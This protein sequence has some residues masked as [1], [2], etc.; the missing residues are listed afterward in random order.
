MTIAA[1]SSTPIAATAGAPPIPAAQPGFGEA[2]DTLLAHPSDAAPNAMPA[3]APTTPTAAATVL[4]AEPALAAMTMPPD[5]LP[6]PTLQPRAPAAVVGSIPEDTDSA[7]AS[8]ADARPASAPDAPAAG[9][10]RSGRA[11]VAWPPAATE[12]PAPFAPAEPIA[13]SIDADAKIDRPVGA[14]VSKANPGSAD[15]DAVADDAGASQPASLPALTQP[16]TVATSIAVPVATLASNAAA[17]PAGASA[18]KGD[19][20][21]SAAATAATNALPTASDRVNKVESD[22]APDAAA[23]SPAA[24]FAD[25][26]AAQAAPAPRQE[27]AGAAPNPGPLAA[28]QPATQATPAAA[29]AAPHQPTVTAQAGQIGR[30]MGVAIA[31]RVQAG[32]SELIVRLNPAEMGRIEVTLAFDHSGSLRA[33]VAAESPAA[34]DLLRRDSADLGRALSDAGVRADAQS[35]R[36]DSGTGSRQQSGER[37][38]G[39]AGS[40]PRPP[41]RFYADEASPVDRPTFRALRTSGRVDLIA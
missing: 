11:V 38:P 23:S 1:T 10:R 16:I 41:G 4:V 34:L 8:N 19:E 21:P 20:L 33:T 2:V 32:G 31:H 3:S 27:S 18:A 40:N 35:F 39:Q 14:K 29:A 25:R 12:A 17:H 7:R 9:L 26:L 5:A 15:S 28:P 37:Q 6:T 22:A 30:E 13:V 24:S 36:F